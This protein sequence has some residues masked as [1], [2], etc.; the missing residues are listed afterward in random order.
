MARIALAFPPAASVWHLPAGISSLAGYLEQ[1]GHSVVQRYSHIAAVEYVFSEQDLPATQDIL[2]TIRDSSAGVMDFYRIRRILESVSTAIQTDQETFRV[3]GNNVTF[4]SK[5]ADG[6]IKGLLSAV[7]SGTHLWKSYFENVE[8]TTARQKCPDIYGISISDERQI[9][10]GFVLA[11]IV[12]RSLPGT[13]VVLGGNVFARLLE[14][15]ALPE[16]AQIFDLCDVIVYSEGYVPLEQIAAGTQLNSVSGIV[17]RDGDRVV[18]NSIT[19]QP[20]AFNTLPAPIIDTSIRQWCPDI[21]P[22]IYTASNCTKSCQ[23]CAISAGSETFHQKTRPIDFQK[24]ACHLSEMGA[25]RFEISD[26]IFHVSRQLELG[27]TLNAAGYHGITWNCYL[28]AT[29]Q[30]LDLQTCKDLYT[31][32]CRGVQ[33]GLES[34]DTNILKGEA[35]EWNAPADYPEILENLTAAGIQVHVFIIVGLPGESMSSTLKW[36]PFLE[37]HGD[38]ILTIKVGRYR[39]ARQAPDEQEISTGNDPAPLRL[40]ADY[41]A[42]QG[43]LSGKKIEALRDVMEEA[44]RRHWGYE[45]TSSIPWWANR[46]RFSLDE[47]RQMAEE[48][49]S[50]GVMHKSVELRKMLPRIQN[51]LSQETGRTASVSS[52]DDIR[53]NL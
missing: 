23:F 14:A 48:L 21:V 13:M 18:V 12:K 10:S 20:V 40:N 22:T 50:N 19:H 53:S 24:L 47:L 38:K 37:R 7:A 31:A 17:Y 3:S 34:L 29:R 4:V 5:R 43:R 15:Y 6:T 32:G 11:E 33:L 27:K 9:V 2:Q 36:I 35:K 39:M 28:D 8:I 49:T 26:E 46:G 51:G 45:L 52:Y 16:F 30:L 44:C 41:K 1:K 25:T 42:P